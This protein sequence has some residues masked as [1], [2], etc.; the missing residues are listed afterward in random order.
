MQAR[1][2]RL[3]RQVA[4]LLAIGSGGCLPALSTGNSLEG[5]CR[6]GIDMLEA[7]RCGP[8]RPGQQRVELLQFELDTFRQQCGDRA[9]VERVQRIEATCVPLYYES[10]R[11]VQAERR[12]VRARFLAEVSELLLDPAYPP[13]ADRENE[14]DERAFQHPKDRAVAREL[15]EVRQQLGALARKHGI[16]PADAKELELW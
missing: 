1:A 5:R 16:A 14:L 4:T 3:V 9:S 13:L 10:E 12:K 11:Q 15:S 8:G 6:Q 7:A 2:R